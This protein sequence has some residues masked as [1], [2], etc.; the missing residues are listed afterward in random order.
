MAN[1][2]KIDMLLDDSGSIKQKTSDT[3]ELNKQLSTAQ[4]LA[5]A[6]Y[7]APMSEGQYNKAR[8]VAG[9]TGASAR[10]FAA[11]AQGLDG[12]VR[13]YATWAANI[14]AAGAAFNALR[15]AANVDNMITGMNQ[16]GVASGMA[17]GSMSKELVRATGGAISLQEAISATV[18]ATA[19]GI[20]T[21]Q[22]QQLGIVATKAS[23]A[24]GVDMNDALSRLTRGITKLE[25]ELLDELGIFTKVGQ[26][27]EAYA[28]SVG[29]SAA[30]LTDFERRQAFANAVLKEGLDKFGEIEIDANPYDKL[31]ASLT[32][33][34]Q[35]ALSLV[36]TAISPLINLLNSSPVALSGVMAALGL[37]IVKQAIPAIGQYKQALTD[38]ADTSAKRWQARADQVRQIE[39]QNYQYLLNMSEAE[40]EKRVSA[41]E[42]A[43]ARIAK[44]RTA[45]T[46]S[47]MAA[48]AQEIIGKTDWQTVSDEDRKYLRDLGK[49]EKQ[50]GN[51]ELGKAYL[52]AEDALRKWTKAERE[53]QDALKQV[54][55]QAHKNIDTLSRYSQQGI[56]RDKAEAERQKAAR[57]GAVS[58]AV[59][60]V[61]TK[62]IREA[63]QNLNMGLA[64]ENLSALNKAYGKIAGGAAI[65][66]TATVNFISSLGAVI[67]WVG[68]AVGTFTLLYSWVSKNG[69]QTQA[70]AGAVDSASE[71][72][73]VATQSIQKFNNVLS[74]Q[75]IEATSN[76][77]AGLS[78]SVVDV[79]DKLNKLDIATTGVDR[80]WENI[81][82]VFGF[83]QQ[84]AAS[85]AISQNIMSLL[86]G[87]KD[88]KLKQE[89]E[90]AIKTTLDVPTIDFAELDD[91]IESIDPKTLK[92]LQ[93]VLDK[94]SISSRATAA[95]VSAIKDSFK[96]VETAYNALG[97]ALKVNDPISNFADAIAKQAG[98]MQQSF[99][100]SGVAA[101][102]FKAVLED[103][104]KLAGFPPQM[105]AQILARAQDYKTLSENIAAVQ[106]EQ[107]NLDEAIAKRASSVGTG[108]TDKASLEA[109]S[110][111]LLQ[112]QAAG[113]QLTKVEAELIKLFSQKRELNISTTN[114]NN[115][116][117][118][119]AKVLSTA[120]AQEM[121]YAFQLA[122]SKT[123]TA[124]AQA[125]IEGQKTLLANLPKSAASADLMAKLEM[126]SISVREKEITAIYELTKQLQI[127][128][129]ESKLEAARQKAMASRGG[130]GRVE[131]QA[132][133]TSL[134]M[135]LEALKNKRFAVQMG[136]GDFKVDSSGRFTEGPAKGMNATAA[137]NIAAAQR[138]YSEQMAGF[139]GQKANI[140]LNAAIE[141]YRNSLTQAAQKNKDNL[142]REE[143]RFEDFKKTDEY[144]RMST[145]QRAEYENNWM[146][147]TADLRKQVATAEQELTVEILKRIT[148][149]AKGTEVAALAQKELDGYVDKYKNRVEGAMPA[150]TAAQQAFTRSERAGAQQRTR[151]IEEE[152]TS[153]RLSES[154]KSFERELAF[155]NEITTAKSA[156]LDI[157]NQLLSKRVE[158]QG[159]TSEADAAE[160]QALAYRTVE[161]DRANKLYLEELTTKRAIAQLELQKVGKSDQDKAIIDQQIKDE[162]AI[163]VLRQ[164]SINRAADGQ[165]KLLDMTDFMS[166]RTKALTGVFQDF[167]TGIADGFVQFAQTGKFEFGDMVKSMLAGL[168][169][170]Q[171][172][173][174][175]MQLFNAANSEGGWVKNLV[176]F[177]VNAFA[178]SQGVPTATTNPIAPSGNVVGIPLGQLEASGG[179]YDGG[180]REFAKGG[181]FTNSIVNSPTLF[182]F[183]KGTGLMGEA[184]PEAIMP[185]KRDS[186][187]TLGVRAEQSSSNVEVVVNNYGK[188]QATV[189]E[190]TDSRG[191]RKI[192]VVV[193][194]MLAGELTR[195]GSVANRA[196]RGTTGSRSPLIRR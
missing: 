28:K 172:Q 193:G 102:T 66:T 74:F 82:G 132:E 68:V 118:D 3:K 106:K 86:E 14:Y 171:L 35:K 69:D 81:K 85:K 75:G 98:V 9:T 159:F 144:A 94:L 165:K 133:L 80:A 50:A 109:L 8:G 111:A 151:T 16:L 46:Q 105:Q 63:W 101:A 155:A 143:K 104:S 108:K 23:R 84:D 45:S 15:Q 148:T 24:L 31:A 122:A 188:E 158:R 89:F 48:R 62:G 78:D 65:A 25:P 67:G 38:A 6:T 173:M 4:K 146:A 92:A 54:E 33:L 163:S 36:N 42:K 191:N 136:N 150:L 30:G 190:T 49:M 178:A 180:V 181:T 32:D 135:E 97:A 176:N 60:D 58:Q 26:A 196:V 129:L 57:L 130:E 161:Q 192:E 83:S 160:Q 27:T 70:L 179:V 195:P 10:D 2:I 131:A 157:E 166:T 43:E 72:Y 13:L 127:N 138:G 123:G 52:R 116:L 168:I 87:I 147:S 73:K 55:A 34:S 90:S 121:Q 115:Q 187:G 51:V 142:A 156:Q 182:K 170:V 44:L 140:Q 194:E 41:V 177:G 18:K 53:H 112:R 145:L 184:G 77:L 175:M 119:S 100:D 59:Q 114:L 12:L 189:Q 139:M 17:L 137:Y 95:S 93:P 64:Q 149:E 88:P 141:G 37:M 79:I 120:A 39:K 134:T 91:A 113:T 126:R 152:L 164:D 76:A 183:A 5:K 186:N 7:A 124:A 99:K 40:A 153:T 185:L 20:N 103:T 19:S 47:P 110:S 107:Q 11:Q 125:Q 162:T 96:E 128:V 61:P 174:Q 29:K 56:T 71:T 154:A 167:F 22:L 169:K 117:K 1:N 21:S